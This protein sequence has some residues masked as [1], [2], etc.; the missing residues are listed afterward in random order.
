MD[1][2]LAAILFVG[3]V[4]D[5]GDVFGIV[6]SEAVSGAISG[7]AHAAPASFG[8]VDATAWVSIAMLVFLGILL[9][10]KVPALI[11]ASLDAKIAEIRKQIDEAERLRIEAEA[12]KSEYE[13]KIDSAVKD[14][15]DM[16]ARS[17]A[18][19]QALMLKAQAAAEALI[20][21]RRKIAEDRIAAAEAG[22]L[23][24]VRAAAVNAA[25]RA[26]EA[27]IAAH[28]DET[29]DKKLVERTINNL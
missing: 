19:A 6:S 10:K 21:R 5:V 7:A 17:E 22:A 1:N 15:E 11:T 20:A 24:E 4:G 28:H 23:A 27:L 9:W 18:E 12:L 29:S 8:L 14:A 3:D 2:M 25:T 13:A 16:A 26:A